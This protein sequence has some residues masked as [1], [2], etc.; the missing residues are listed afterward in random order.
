MIHSQRGFS[1][2]EVAV[3][4]VILSVAA[5]ALS[6]M[7]F[8]PVAKSADPAGITRA[9]DLVQ[10][11]LET[12]LGDRNNPLVGFALI[13]AARYPA[14]SPAA[15]GFPG[16]SRTTAVDYVNDPNLDTPVSPGPTPYKRVKVTISWTGGYTINGQVLLSD[17]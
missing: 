5:L 15:L 17:Y 13:N 1:L 7:L 8:F 2:V 3:A 14:E 10:E 6:K 16:F 4:I 9:Q 11:K 12:V